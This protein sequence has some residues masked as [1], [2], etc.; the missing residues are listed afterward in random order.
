[1][2]GNPIG[3]GRAIQEAMAQVRGSRVAQDTARAVDGTLRALRERAETS[4]ASAA[5]VA[6]IREA[7]DAFSEGDTARAVQRLS[8]ALVQCT[9][10]PHD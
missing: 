6:A 8:F 7:E 9:R 10:G 3:L 1:M 2:S 4:G 5:I